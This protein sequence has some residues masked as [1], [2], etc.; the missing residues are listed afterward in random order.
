[1]KKL[2]AVEEARFIMTQGMEW[3]AFKW[4]MESPKCAR[5]PIVRPRPEHAEDKVK[6]T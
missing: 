2:E 1:M 5:L 6:A 3:G 4:L